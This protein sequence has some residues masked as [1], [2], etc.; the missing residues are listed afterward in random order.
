MSV[1]ATESTKSQF[2]FLFSPPASIS[3]YFQDPKYT[4]REFRDKSKSRVHII[5]VIVGKRS[6]V[7]KQGGAQISDDEW[8]ESET[9]DKEEQQQQ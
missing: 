4:T 6:L 9:E 8:E 5:S 7:Y 2:F 3:L 1:R